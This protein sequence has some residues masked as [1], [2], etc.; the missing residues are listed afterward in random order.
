M[1]ERRSFRILRSLGRSREIATVLLNY[2]FGDVVERLG[3][4]RYIQWGR[5]ILSRRATPQTSLTRPQ[6]I[7][8][9]LEALGPTFIKFGQVLSTRPDLV[10]PDLICELTKLQEGVPS[11]PVEKAI[12]TLESELGNTVDRLFLQFDRNPLA[13]GSLGQVHRAQ[14]FDGTSLAV[15]IRRPNVVREVERDLEL[16]LELSIL[17]ERHV[18]ES[19]VFE[20]TGL[21]SQFARSIR[22]EMNFIREARTIDEFSRLFK[23]DKTLTVP[24]VYWELSGEAIITMSYLDGFKVSDRLGMLNAGLKREELAANGGK[25]F[26]KQVFEFGLF[27]GDPHPGNVRMMRDGS[28]GL[29]DFGMVGRLEEERREELVDIF[30]SI[31]QRDVKRAVEL[32]LTVGRPS[33][34][35][36]R[37]LLQSDVRDFI[38]TY[39]G[40]ALE[41]VKMGK[42]LSD[43]VLILSNHS[44]RFPADLMLLLRAMVTLDGL[45]R[46]LD[47]EFN[48]AL[49]LAPF[50][51]KMIRDRYTPHRMARRLLGNSGRVLEAMQDVPIQIEKTLQKLNRDEIKIILEHRSLDYLVTELDRSGNRI[52]VGMVMSSLILASALIVRTSSSF[53]SPWFPV[54][55]FVL[56]S[57]LGVWLV[58]GIFRSGRL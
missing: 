22:R 1:F 36:D 45:G 32:V 24:K 16:M 29:I 35:V 34:E 33:E 41:R 42:L 47:P 5:R 50:I 51:K 55:A 7:R 8:L 48:L 14:H 9:A 40:L 6:R 44:I 31:S 46:D 54:T 58:Y 23:K 18:P 20:P 57:L 38:E 56:S 10:P 19:R 15:K 21:V 26:L 27:H 39:Y 13:A 11:F 49:Y 25:I 28:I 52:V 4:L 3:L 30:L 17:I 53:N 43:F 37:P 12:E 2:G